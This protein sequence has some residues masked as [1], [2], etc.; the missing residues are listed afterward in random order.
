MVCNILSIKKILEFIDLL[1][2]YCHCSE[3]ILV[4]SDYNRIASNISTR[5]STCYY[6]M[7]IKYK[8]QLWTSYLSW[9]DG[10]HLMTSFELQQYFALYLVFP[11]YNRRCFWWKST[12]QKNSEH[13]TFWWR[14]HKDENSFQIIKTSFGFFSSADCSDYIIHCGMIVYICAKI[15]I[16]AP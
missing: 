11:F 5:Q 7:L 6:C 4:C 15:R 1:V 3:H 9:R 10:K 16:Y 8:D 14:K 12:V 2:E 13:W